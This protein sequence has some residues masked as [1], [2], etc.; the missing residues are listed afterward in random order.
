MKYSCPVVGPGWEVQAKPSAVYDAPNF[1]D[2]L[3]TDVK[4]AWRAAAQLVPAWLM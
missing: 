3:L 4:A 1:T 2:G